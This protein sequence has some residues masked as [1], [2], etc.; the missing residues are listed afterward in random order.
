VIHLN[1]SS[2]SA[3]IADTSPLDIQDVRERLSVIVS[4][5]YR[6]L[7]QLGSGGM[8]T[9][10]L[11][12]HRIHGALFALKVLHPSLADVPELKE[13]FYREAMHAGALAEHPNIVSVL[14][15]DYADGLHYLVMP[16]I[17][18][19]DLG[20]ALKHCGRFHWNDAL[21]VV[22]EIA[23]ILD[24]AE[25]CGIY[26]GDLTP[27]NVR[28]DGFGRVLLLDFGLSRSIYIAEVQ[29]AYKLG[30]PYAMS[31]EQISGDT[32][33]IRSDLYAAGVLL[34]ELLTGYPPF[35]GDT[36]EAIEEQHLRGNLLI[37]PQIKQAHEQLPQLLQSLLAKKAKDRPQNAKSLEQSLL[38]MG[39]T[40][41]P[42]DIASLIPQEKSDT[43]LR[44]R[45][46]VSVGATHSVQESGKVLK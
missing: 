4:G 35:R 23:I 17:R 8:S 6:I 25:T 7:K 37:P 21:T 13:M 2:P 39:A 45:L 1:L 5:K 40:H 30:T 14:D 10:W 16:Y 12:R 33:D 44:R 28:I 42:L 32:V 26:H 15:I 20:E 36:I 27:G 19:V 43:P 11:A 34:F 29:S 31:P 3:R 38:R 18:G 22:L 46:S 41:R 24:Y 9:V